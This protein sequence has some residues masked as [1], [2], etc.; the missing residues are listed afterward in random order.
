LHYK[1]YKKREDKARKTAPE[2]G[3]DARWT[4]ARKFFLKRHPFCELC[5][6]TGRTTKATVVHHVIDHKG[7][8]ELFWDDRNWMA[9][10]KRCHDR[11]TAKTSGWG[12]GRK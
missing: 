9:L 3:Y 2:R 7:N 8:Q 12:R 6:Q 10:C 11:L 4:K 1:E 5:M